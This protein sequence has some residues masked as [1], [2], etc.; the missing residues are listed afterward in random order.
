MLDWAGTMFYLGLVVP[1]YGG[2]IHV[3][4]LLN[5]LWITFFQSSCW[6]Y[7]W[8]EAE[9]SY[10]LAWAFLW[11]WVVFHMHEL[12]H[13]LAEYARELSE[14]IWGSYFVQSYSFCINI[15]PKFHKGQS[16]FMYYVMFTY[17]QPEWLWLSLRQ[18][19]SN[20][21]WFSNSLSFPGQL[22]IKRHFLI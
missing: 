14:G 8:H 1:H 15:S 18:T 9:E 22:W 5:A 16:H 6:G 11:P 10:S 4:T 20:W 21:K 7:T 3:N 13:P 2:K 17:C 19:S 12:T